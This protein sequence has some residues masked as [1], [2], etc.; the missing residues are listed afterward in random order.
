MRRI[1]SISTAL[2]GMAALT[3]QLAYVSAIFTADSYKPR[4]FLVWFTTG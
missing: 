3:M 2:A 4:L 1:L